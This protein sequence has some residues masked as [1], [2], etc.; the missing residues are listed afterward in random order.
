MTQAF[1]NHHLVPATT[2]MV[3]VI[4]QRG[5]VATAKLTNDRPIKLQPGKKASVQVRIPGRV[6]LAQVKLVLNDPPEGVSL[7]D[8]RFEQ[9]RVHIVFQANKAYSTLVMVKI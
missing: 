4:E 8:M 3:S 5:P 1:V 2:M 6:P 7:L 9:R